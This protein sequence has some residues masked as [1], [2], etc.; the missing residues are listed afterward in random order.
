MSE[1]VQLEAQTRDTHGKAQARRMRREDGRVPGVVY[2]AKKAPV[3][4]SLPHNKVVKA[5][6]HESFYSQVLDL[7]IDG[8][9][10]KVVLKDLQRHPYKSVILHMDFMRVDANSKLTMTVPLHFINEEAAVGVKQGGGVISHNLTEVEV[11]CLPADLPEYIEVDMAAIGLDQTLHLSDIQLPKGVEIVALTHGDD[12]D[13]A[14]VGISAPRAQEEIPDGA[15]QAGET[16]VLGEKS[17]D[18]E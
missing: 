1:L 11:I 16:E 2:G 7:K 8:N 5:L 12:H 6:E 13:Y 4:I 14:V 17:G 18:G 15:P 10:E 3:S 9:T